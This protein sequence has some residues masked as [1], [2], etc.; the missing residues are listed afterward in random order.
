MAVININ[1]TKYT[2]QEE[3]V[4]AVLKLI[5]DSNRD[6]AYN[7]HRL[8]IYYYVDECGTARKA[9]DRNGK[10]DRIRFYNNNYFST[11]NEAYEYEAI[12][13]LETNLRMYA[14]AYNGEF[15]SRDKVHLYCYAGEVRYGVEP[16]NCYIPNTIW[17]SDADIADQAVEYFGEDRIRKYLM[18][19]Q[20]YWTVK[21]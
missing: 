13:L 12:R 18:W 9:Q 14:A 15:N 11:I 16:H 10:E 6:T 17:F 2:V 1:D 3:T 20:D 21:R 5:G 19:Q 7:E 8:E 4:K